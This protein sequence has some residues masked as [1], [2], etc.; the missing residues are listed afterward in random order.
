MKST[1]FG[2]LA[3][4]AVCAAPVPVLAQQTQGGEA[5]WALAIHGGAGVINRSELSPERDALYRQGLQQALDAGQAVLA[6]NGSAL[7]A[8]EAAVRVLEDNPLFNAG[9]GAVFT[10]DGRNELDAAI[11]D[12]TDLNAA[13]VAGL[14]RT[15]NPIRAARAVMERSPHVMLIG[16]GAEVFADSIGLEKVAPAYYFTESR[17]Q[18]LERALRGRGEAIPP[19][20]EGAPPAPAVSGPAAPLAFNLHEAPL[21]ERKFGTVGAVALD[22]QG[23]IAA[24]TSTGGTTGKRWGRVGDVPVIGA[25]TYASNAEG[26]AVSATGAG[27]YFIR[28]TVARDIC[29]G[30]ASGMSLKQAAD[31][32]IA[33]VGRLGGDGGVIAVAPDGTIAFSMNTSGMYRGAVSS[34]AQ[35]RV[36][37]YADEENQ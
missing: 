14:T 27:E 35:P 17:W 30:T 36:A 20:P 21:D 5:P 34:H 4:I 31:A 23:R 3:A 13:A 6:A 28:A 7:D 12:G 26:C 33:E 29:H 37:I 25:G 22:R 16:E 8:V 32:E 24:A 19:R 1:T 15:R 18:A 10:S 2:L 11:M 9:K